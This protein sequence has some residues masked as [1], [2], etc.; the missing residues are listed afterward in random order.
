MPRVELGRGQFC[1]GY[2]L[3]H[4]LHGKCVLKVFADPLTEKKAV[5][6]A[7]K[8]ECDTPA[9]AKPPCVNVSKMIA[10]VENRAVLLQPRGT[11]FSKDKP[12]TADEISALVDAV[13]GMGTTTETSRST[14]CFV[15]E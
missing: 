8:R 12:P 2:E 9:A 6:A 5:H 3:D 15:V 11:C 1:V 10:S 14:T 13:K 7:W 4:L